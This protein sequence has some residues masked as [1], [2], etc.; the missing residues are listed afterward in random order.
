MSILE[1]GTMRRRVHKDSNHDAV[2]AE[3]RAHG[4]TVLE[5]HAL[6]NGLP[7]LIVGYRGVTALVELKNGS[8]DHQTIREKRER[9]ARQAAYLA[10]W[11]GGPAFV[12]TSTEDV[13]QR[14][15]GTV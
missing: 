14:L 2:V 9:L 6:G 5:T 1:L 4:A 10:R 11:A 13:L 12:A 15:R 8:R 3:L 7:D